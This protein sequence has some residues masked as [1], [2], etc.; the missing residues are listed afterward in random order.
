MIQFNFI[1][2]SVIIEFIII[3]VLFYPYIFLSKSIMNNLKLNY[4]PIFFVLNTIIFLLINYYI[5][6]YLRCKFSSIHIQKYRQKKGITDQNITSSQKLYIKKWKQ[7]IKKEAHIGSI[8]V[9][10]IASPFLFI[11]MF[12]ATLSN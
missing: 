6:Y 9:I 4:I 1:F 7:K 8:V 3:A 2:V 12:S 5:N 10:T 11:S